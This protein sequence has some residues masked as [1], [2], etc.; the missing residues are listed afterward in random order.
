MLKITE[1]NCGLQAVSKIT[2][3]PWRNKNAPA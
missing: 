3:A 2:L 1:Y